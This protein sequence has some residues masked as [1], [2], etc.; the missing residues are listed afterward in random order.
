MNPARE[1]VIGVA[2]VSDRPQLG[3]ALSSVLGPEFVVL[4]CIVGK[5]S[6]RVP[7]LD[8][9]DVVLYDIEVSNSDPERGESFFDALI[10]SGAAVIVM[11]GH[12]DRA[13]ALRLVERGAEGSIEKPPNVPE[14]KTVLRRAA[15][16]RRLK[17][18][19]DGARRKR[20]LVEGFEQL[21]GSSAPM[22]MVYKL[23][24]KVA[25]LAAPVLITGESGTGKE[26]VARAIHNTGERAGRPFVPV[27]CAAI[28]ESLIE[29]ELF[30]HEKGAFTGSV[31]ARAGYFEQAADGTLFLDEI[32]ELPQQI[33]VKLLRVLQEREF[34]RLGS[35]RAIPLRARVL[36]A[37]HRDL[38]RL[39]AAGEFRQDLFYRVNVM[40][41]PLPALRNRAADLPVLAHHFLDKYSGMY[42]KPIE[43]IE[44]DALARIESYTWPGNVRELENAIQSAIILAENATIE[45]ADLPAALQDLDVPEFEEEVQPTGSFERMLREYKVKLAVNAIQQC[46]G[47]KTLAAQSLSISRAYLHRLIRQAPGIETEASGAP[48]PIRIVA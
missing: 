23:I 18:E 24:R 34:T 6:G 10:A 38:S 14:L 4:S 22:Q 42:G 27:S 25:N 36:Y 47:N 26:L 48:T 40:N 32:G 29:S 43:G 45:S 20:D 12:D 13:K 31:G 3:V 28:P 35:S 37:T 8:R 7:A 5:T 19:L 11:A 15:E 39:V 16:N 41:I 2:V 9:A 1:F 30:G 33:Q 21:K 44:P 46:N 17:Q